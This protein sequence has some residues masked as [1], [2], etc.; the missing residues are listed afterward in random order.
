MGR[1][2]TS[3]TYPLPDELRGPF[4]TAVT[5][6][7]SYAALIILLGG[8]NVNVGADPED[9]PASGKWLTVGFEKP[10]GPSPETFEGWLTPRL[11]IKSEC[12]RNLFTFV[13]AINWHSEVHAEVFD[14]LQNFRPSLSGGLN[15]GNGSVVER[16]DMMDDVMVDADDDTYYFTAFYST[17]IIAAHAA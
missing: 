3:N 8:A 16:E 4:L 10:N 7:L 15:G 12:R 5:D 6:R 17:R 9:K 11:W 14:R 13:G 1:V 2:L